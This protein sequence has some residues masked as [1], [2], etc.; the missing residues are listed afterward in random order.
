MVAVGAAA[1]RILRDGALRTP[2]VGG[3][4]GVSCWEEA[5]HHFG[6]RFVNPSEELRRQREVCCHMICSYRA[7]CTEVSLVSLSQMEEVCSCTVGG[8]AAA[9]F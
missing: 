2:P 4:S 7:L 5:G 9:G 3:A 1:D 8:A 6:L